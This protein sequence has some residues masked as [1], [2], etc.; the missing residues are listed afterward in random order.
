MIAALALDQGK[1][2]QLATG[3]GK[4]LAAVLPA[5]A[6]ALAGYGVHVFS[7]NDYLARRR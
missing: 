7:A 4:T 6:N 2:V 1:V 3:E 5:A